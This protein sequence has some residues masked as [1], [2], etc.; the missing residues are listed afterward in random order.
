[1]YVVAAASTVASFTQPS[2]GVSSSQRSI[3]Y[4]SAPGTVA[5]A[6]KIAVEERD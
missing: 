4:P 5:H 3:V 1:M 2:S 6:R